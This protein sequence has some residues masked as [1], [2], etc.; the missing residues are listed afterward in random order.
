M[1]TLIIFK[2]IYLILNY[3]LFL[4]AHYLLLKSRLVYK[5]KF[6]NFIMA[7]V[8]AY[9]LHILLPLQATVIT[10]Q[11]EAISNAINILIVL[12]VAFPWYLWIKAKFSNI[13]KNA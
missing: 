7:L 13:L 12:A 11:D 8:I 5:D 2:I 10:F 9:I 1:E 4:G 3:L 6:M